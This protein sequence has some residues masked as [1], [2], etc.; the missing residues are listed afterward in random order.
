MR[1]SD[2]SSDVCSSDL[3]ASGC[4]GRPGNRWCPGHGTGRSPGLPPVWPGRAGWHGSAL[5]ARHGALSAGHLEHASDGDVRAMAEEGTVAVLPPGAYYF[6]RETKLP[7]VEA[8]RPHGTHTGRET[9]RE[10]GC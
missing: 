6:L 3:K 1:I 8:M 9:W 7:P 2:W 4:G 5:A 10:R